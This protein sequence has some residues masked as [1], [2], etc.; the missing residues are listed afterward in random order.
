MAKDFSSDQG[1]KQSINSTQRTPK[2]SGVPKTGFTEAPKSES[3]AK[4]PGPAVPA[5]TTKIR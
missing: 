5:N 4:G 1:G 2:N 3:A